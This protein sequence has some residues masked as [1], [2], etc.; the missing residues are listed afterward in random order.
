VIPRDDSCLSALAD[1]PNSFRNF[2]RQ[3]AFVLCRPL[4]A[5]TSD[6]LRKMR[7][8]CGDTFSTCPYWHVENVP[9]HCGLAALGCMEQSAM[10]R[11]LAAK[12]RG[13]AF[14]AARDGA[15]RS[16][17]WTL[18]FRFCGKKYRT[19][20]GQAASGTLTARNLCVDDAVAYHVQP[21]VSMKGRNLHQGRESVMKRFPNRYP[22]V[23][24]SA[25]PA[26]PS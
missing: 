24:R 26:N 12:R 23:D 17:P 21:E 22:L 19:L 11:P 7:R 15:L 8:S 10:H 9:P 4:W 13:L 18:R 16:A 14:G 25:Q 2:L 1:N 6:L 5:V 20:F 3:P